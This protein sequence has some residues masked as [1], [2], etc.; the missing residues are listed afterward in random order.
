MLIPRQAITAG[1]LAPGRGKTTWPARSA[2][3]SAGTRR[4]AWP[5]ATRPPARCPPRCASS[6]TAPW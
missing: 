2:V 3:V 6:T 1:P 5:P 4:A